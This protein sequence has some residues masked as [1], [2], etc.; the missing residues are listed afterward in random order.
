MV[1]GVLARQERVAEEAHRVSS[2][3]VDR[4]HDVEAFLERRAVGDVQGPL[5]DVAPRV[6]VRDQGRCAADRLSTRHLDG[7]EGPPVAA[8]CQRPHGLH[9]EERVARATSVRAPCLVDAP[10]DVGV[11]ADPR[12]EGEA[13]PVEGAERDR[14]GAVGESG[15]AHLLGC[16]THLVRQAQRARQHAGAAGGQQPDRDLGADAVQHVVRRAVPGEHDDRV[17]AEVDR[18]AREVARL[19]GALGRHD[20]DAAR[21]E[22]EHRLF[23]RAGVRPGRDRVHDEPEDRG[24]QRPSNRGARFSRNASTPSR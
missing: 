20:L 7:Q 13:A 18:L 15:L 8:L 3:E 5:A 23:E 4:D 24:R 6:R 14:A 1:V 17:V 19:P 2:S 9:R 11:E 21:L 10:H 22:C 16:W 12:G